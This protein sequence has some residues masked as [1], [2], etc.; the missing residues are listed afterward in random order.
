MSPRLTARYR[1]SGFTR[2]LTL[3]FALIV[4]VVATSIPVAFYSFATIRTNTTR[5]AEASKTL[6]Q[7]GEFREAIA[8]MRVSA[9]DYANSND[10]A[11][12][13]ALANSLNQLTNQVHCI[14]S[15]AKCDRR[16]T[17]GAMP[18]SERTQWRALIDNASQANT[19]FQTSVR[20]GRAEVGI[21][22][23]D[24]RM[25]T[26]VTA[27]ADRLAS[28]VRQRGRN[29]QKEI[30]QSILSSAS[31]L[32][33]VLG[34]AVLLAALL[35]W[36]VP[37]QLMRRLDDLRRA[38]HQIAGGDYTARASERRIGDDE[39]A[40]LIRDFNK[41]GI[42]L[43]QR[44]DENK[45]L[46][47]Q[48]QVALLGEQERSTRDPL[49]SLR[50]HRYFQEALKS[51]VDRCQRSRSQVTVAMLDLDDF[52]Q[53]NDRFGH[54]EGDAVLMRITKGISDSLRTYDLACRLGGEEFGIIFPDTSPENAQQILD[55]IAEHVV[56]FGP[57][58]ERATFSAGIATYP[59]HATT[60]ADLC[61]RADEA[62]YY[63]KSN[64]KAQ[65][66]IYDPFRVTAMDSTERTDQ[67]AKDAV[68]TTATTLASSVDR[69]DPYTRNHSELTAVY[70]ATIGRALEM[71]EQTVKNLYRAALL[72][73]VGKI[74]IDESILRKPGPL[75][76]E[77]WAQVRK[78]PELSYRF[79]E[80]G[81]MEPIA[82]WTRHH[83]ERWDGTGYP[84][85]LAGEAIPLGSR[86][87]FVAD[88][89]E[90]MTSDRV[91]QPA[92]TI[93][94]ALQELIAYSGT[95]FDAQI[96][97]TMVRLVHA[98]VFDQIHAQYGKPPGAG[99]MPMPMAPPQVDEGGD[100]YPMAA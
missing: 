69:K 46:Q 10:R 18:L 75:D 80:A 59:K 79:L 96:A 83:H 22:Q 73:D 66:T 45:L 57:N 98:G 85:G 48:L 49:T 26:Q 37:R 33:F 78:H 14:Q 27:P 50:N 55:R 8:N 34:I 30:D 68:L 82:T 60:P 61:Q 31:L 1:A 32:I 23:F 19:Q 29:A 84:D 97:G 58:G 5:A 92:L 24:S 43:L 40:R 54:H 94:G 67:R 62:S 56:G 11:D 88:A 2:K 9:R 86:I 12:S 25:R 100:S 15:P 20:R 17:Y 38:A 72:H 99:I 91:Y 3:A 53:V 77:E 76:A 4:C 35:A 6:E 21:R 36:W 87:I 65:T 28:L 81:E 44:H 47:Q 52:K 89:F 42:G 7:V 63:S 16:N 41:M 70:A 93:A 64:G 71:D 90:A 39:M 74:G 51:E 13:V 95:Q